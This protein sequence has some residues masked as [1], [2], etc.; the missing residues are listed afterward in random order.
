[1]SDAH[2]HDYGEHDREPDRRTTAPMSEFTAR[3][4]GLGAVVALVGLA[5]AVVLP[6]VL[7]L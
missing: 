7:T 5:V 3:E 1:M 4:A 6:L 2:E